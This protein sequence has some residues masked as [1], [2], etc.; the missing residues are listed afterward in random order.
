MKTAISIPDQL[1]QEVESLSRKQRR[2]R[3][4][5]FVMAVKELLEKE[6]S[7][8]LLEALNEAYSEEESAE[9]TTL[10]E[11]GKR[12]YGKKVLKENHGD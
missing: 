1:F 2:S 9:E 3:S 8:E 11:K 5:V 10:R 12:Y 7:R 6:K 4:E